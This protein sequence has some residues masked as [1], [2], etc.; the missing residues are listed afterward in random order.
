MTGDGEAGRRRPPPPAARRKS[1]AGLARGLG[2]WGRRSRRAPK[3]CGEGRRIARRMPPKNAP[4]RV[5]R[6]VARPPPPRFPGRSAPVVA[7]I[8][9]LGVLDTREVCPKRGREGRRAKTAQ[10][11]E[12][13]NGA[14]ASARF[15]WFLIELSVAG[16]LRST[17]QA[18]WASTMIDP[19]AVHPRGGVEGLCHRRALLADAARRGGGQHHFLARAPRPQSAFASFHAPLPA[20]PAL[21]G[22]QRGST[23]AYSI[24]RGGG[25]AAAALLP[26]R[27]RRR[28]GRPPPSSSERSSPL[29]NALGSRAGRERRG[30]RSGDGVAARLRR[31]RPPRR[32]VRRRPPRSPPST[33]AAAAPL[34]PRV[35]REDWGED[36]K[37]RLRGEV[38]FAPREPCSRVGRERRAGT[39]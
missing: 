24:S 3:G 6:S 8:P 34:E 25:G 20:A 38:F 30:R 15:Q 18:A 10:N 2:A 11:R 5:R 13:G 27:R 31:A 23:S 29:V 21:F 26:F 12:S 28:A 19:P 1:N 37:A 7:S 36:A 9:A 4:L 39:G 32:R 16:E 17:L 22:S 14:T 35:E 33:V